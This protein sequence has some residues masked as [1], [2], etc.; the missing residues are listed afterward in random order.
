MSKTSGNR[1]ITS[2]QKMFANK[3]L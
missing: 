2:G 1:R 3:C